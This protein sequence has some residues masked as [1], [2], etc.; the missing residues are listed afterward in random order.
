LEADLD[1]TVELVSQI[2][3]MENTDGCKHYVRRAKLVCPACDTPYWCRHCHDEE[4]DAEP[5]VKKRHHL[6]RSKVTHI[7]CGGCTLRQPVAAFC[8]NTACG[9]TFGDYTCIKCP[10]Y[11]DRVERQYFHCDECTICRV[12]GRDNYFHCKVCDGCFSK[13]MENSHTCVERS[14]HQ[15]CPVCFEYQFDSIH[16]NTVLNCGHAIHEHCLTELLS[17]ENATGIA[18]TCPIC[19]KS[20]S[21]YSSYWE[22]LDREIE[23]HPVPEEYKGWR[24]DI[25]CNDCSLPSQGIPFH[26]IGLK[27][28][29]CGS[30]N[31]QRVSLVTD[32]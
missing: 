4:L 3:R 1:K 28:T 21:D 32:N 12:G 11:D 15:N 7:V 22:L 20:I 24:A 13:S 5:D 23:L 14:L 25:M 8:S 2:E 30:Y 17:E 29:H 26:L 18:P 19:K 9:I 16:P 31:T 6:D 27:C 10:F